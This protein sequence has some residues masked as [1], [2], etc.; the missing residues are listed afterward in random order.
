LSNR[1]H[2]TPMLVQ[3]QVSLGIYPVRDMLREAL[4]RDGFEVVPV[5][6]VREALSRIAT[7]NFDLL[8]SDLHAPPGRQPSLLNS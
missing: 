2:D 1:I 3:Q 5:A 7:E 6:N 8:L 4:E